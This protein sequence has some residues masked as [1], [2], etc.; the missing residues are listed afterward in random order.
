MNYII[1]RRGERIIYS[2]HVHKLVLIY[3][4]RSLQML[5]TFLPILHST[6]LNLHENK[7]FWKVLG[8][9]GNLSSSATTFL[10]PT[11]ISPGA[12]TNDIWG[13]G[14]CIIQF[15]S[16]VLWQE[17]GKKNFAFFIVFI[18]VGTV[19]DEIKLYKQEKETFRG[20]LDIACYLKET[21]NV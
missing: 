5:Y 4:S 8:R 11:L 15:H 13:R 2:S 18:G 7:F 20:S 3:W 10:S 1:A 19:I 21:I 16:S 12:H 9:L 17:N 6:P 14:F